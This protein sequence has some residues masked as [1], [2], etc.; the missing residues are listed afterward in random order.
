VVEGESEDE[1]QK[2]EE[3][4]ILFLKRDIFRQ[5]G[6]VTGTKKRIIQ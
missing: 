3:E 5:R 4:K 1:Q 2:T 6:R